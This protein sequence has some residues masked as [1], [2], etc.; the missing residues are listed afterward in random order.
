M[1]ARIGLPVALRPRTRTSVYP[2]RVAALA[3]LAYAA[4]AAV[5]IVY[6]SRIAAQIAPTVADLGQI[7]RFK[8]LVFVATTTLFLFLFAW[9][10]LRRI[11]QQQDL[12]G[13]QM[14]ALAR[15]D[16][17]MLA[18]M[19]A[20]AMAH[21]VR[22]ALMVAMAVSEEVSGFGRP[23]RSR[24]ES[25]QDLRKALEAIAAWMERLLRFTSEKFAESEEMFDVVQ[26]VRSATDLCRL[27]ERLSRRTVDLVVPEQPVEMRGIP[28]LVSR[29]L[30]NLILNA[31]DA[32]K[33]G[34]H[35]RVS[36]ERGG[37]E[38]TGTEEVVL[39]VEDDGPGVPLREREAILQPFYTSK[40]EQGGGLGLISFVACAEQHHGEVEVGDSTLGGARFELRLPSSA[41]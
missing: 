18:G 30:F 38:R 6:S 29:A 24:E 20:A 10:F 39:R 7:E 32:T 2:V 23:A 14:D 17:S 5:Y 22:N 8:G 36:I 34:G 27:H 3:A 1:A 25:V 16:R 13:R 31:A 26:Q 41:A 33:D 9:L 15:A 21:D 37:A 28:Q 35:I 40:G 19:F 4:L 12:I 11:R